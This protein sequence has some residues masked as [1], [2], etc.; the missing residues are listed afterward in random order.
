MLALDTAV[1]PLGRP[2]RFALDLLLDLSRLLPYTGDDDVVRL[3][4]LDGSTRAEL[5]ALRS[6]AWTI[7]AGNGTVTIERGLLTFVA[8]IAGAVVEQRSAAR[9]RFDR[10]PATENE[11]VQTH[12]ERDPVVSRIAHELAAAVKRAAGRRPVRFVAPWPEGRRWAVALTHDVD[13]VSW[14]PAFTAMRMAELAINGRLVRLFDVLA[15]AVMN[16]GRRVVWEGVREVLEI[17]AHYGARTTWFFLCGT[18]TFA[19]ARAGDL[20]Y[21]PESPAARR[22]IDA[23]RDAGHEVGLHGSF[24]TSETPALFAEQRARL[25]AL[26]GYDA[27]GV[28]Q[29]F[30]RLRPDATYR[31]MADT[32]FSFDSTAGFADRNGFRLGVADVLPMWHDATQKP[33]S[34]DEAPFTW[35]DRALSKYH[36]VENPAEWVR[37]ALELADVVRS[38]E[39]LWVGIWHPN[40]TGPL[41]FPGALDAYEDLVASL[42]EHDPWLP[43]LSDAVAWRRARRAVRAVGLDASGTVRVTSTGAGAG[44][45][46]LEDAEGRPVSSDVDD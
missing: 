31:D 40:L 1:I 46:A 21:T 39:G 8:R 12:T 34:L 6:R 20:T 22:I 24:A 5:D 23:V 9:D 33:L 42:V 29:H 4:V 45:V 38:V 11:L 32:G 17:E 30:L 18:P 36:G 28:R 3:R 16:A 44:Q 7:L 26:A 27:A 19:T 10:V 25:A 2:E 14:W 35:M 15:E 43:T 41:G 37:D 13:V